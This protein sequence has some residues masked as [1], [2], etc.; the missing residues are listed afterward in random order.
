M[1]AHMRGSEGTGQRGQGDSSGG[2]GARGCGIGSEA[3]RRRPEN[4][5]S[6]TF[7]PASSSGLAHVR[8]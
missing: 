8:T 6:W 1:C 7:A 5:S 2:G 4:A 3:Q